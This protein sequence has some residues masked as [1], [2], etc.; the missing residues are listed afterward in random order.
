MPTSPKMYAE[1]SRHDY[2]RNEWLNEPMNGLM[3]RWI[4]ESTN[5]KINETMKQWTNEWTNQWSKKKKNYEGRK[6]WFNENETMN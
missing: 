3:K 6:Q 1:W 5:R 4:S 2:L